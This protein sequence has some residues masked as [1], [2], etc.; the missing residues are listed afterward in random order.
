MSER[1]AIDSALENGPNLRERKRQFVRR[2]LSDAAWNLFAVQ[3]YEETTVAEIATA[4]GVSRRTF[5]R[6]FPTKD[7]VLVAT[8]DELA[9]EMLAAVAARPV[10][11]APLLAICQALV[12][13]LEAQLLAHR[14]RSRTIIRLLRESPSLRRAM[15]DRHARMEERLAAHFADRLA[16]DPHT[17]AR[18]ALIAFVARALLDTAFN[19]W[20][21]QGR[22]DVGELV[23]ELAAELVQLTQSPQ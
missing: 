10:E 5:F 9:D 11:E 16:A 14:D 13:V 19:V 7:D 2:E 12:P 21:D 4:A 17:D 6:Y 23:D 22:D 20:Y 3:G 1:A 8:T 18:P 15:L